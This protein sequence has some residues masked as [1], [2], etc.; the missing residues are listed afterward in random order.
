M[1]DW[2]KYGGQANENL[3]HGTTGNNPQRIVDLICYSVLKA[4]GVNPTILQLIVAI[5]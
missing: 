2:T 5:L 1:F 3:F 4:C